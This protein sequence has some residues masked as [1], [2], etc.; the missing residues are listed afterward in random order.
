MADQ[1][2][3]YTLTDHGTYLRFKDKIDLQPL[4]TE[5]DS[6]HNPYGVLVVNPDKHPMT[7][8]ELAN[9]FAD[10]LISPRGQQIIQDFTVDGERLF[11]PLR[12]PAMD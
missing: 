1:M 12:L 10:F 3:A 4:V 9:A 11:H 8:S 7:Q 5:H 6:L 2:Q